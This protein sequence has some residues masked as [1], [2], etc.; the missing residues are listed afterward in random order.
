MWLLLA[1]EARS[2]ELAGTVSGTA[3]TAVK[4]AGDSAAGNRI[5]QKLRSAGTCVK[6]PTLAIVEP[7]PGPWDDGAMGSVDARHQADKTGTTD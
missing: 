2:C 1:L 6:T 4:R 7:A 3:M 5:A